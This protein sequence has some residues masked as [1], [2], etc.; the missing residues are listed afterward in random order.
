M[1]G[2]NICK[3]GWIAVGGI[4]VMVVVVMMRSLHWGGEEG[5]Q[6]QG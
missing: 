3:D 6:S 1:A 2:V 4:V 5:S